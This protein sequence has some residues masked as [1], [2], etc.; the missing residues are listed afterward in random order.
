MSPSVDC[1]K[2]WSLRAFS[3]CSIWVV[4]EYSLV[5]QGSW[6]MGFACRVWSSL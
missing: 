2:D 6:T 4:A 3:F 1:D 5:G